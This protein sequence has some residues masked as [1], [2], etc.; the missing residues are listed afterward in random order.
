[1]Q[2]LLSR[3]LPDNARDGETA[4]MG[5]RKSLAFSLEHFWRILVIVDG[6]EPERLLLSRQRARHGFDFL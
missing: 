6:A 2:R 1:M 4:S 3:V 5:C